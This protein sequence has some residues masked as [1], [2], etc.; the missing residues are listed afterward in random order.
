MNHPFVDG[1][2]RAGH[3]AMETFLVLNGHEIN[4][5]RDEQ[6]QIIL[7]VA[8]GKVGREDFTDWL[9]THMVEKRD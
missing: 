8:E 6:E 3:A 9:R 2:K 1:N 4:A 7:Q 5:P